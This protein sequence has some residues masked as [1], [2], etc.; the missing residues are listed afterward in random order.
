MTNGEKLRAMSDEELS[1]KIVS[2]KYVKYCTL[3]IFDKGA[4]CRHKECEKCIELW[5]KEESEIE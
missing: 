1:K 5:L 2:G 3:D 4:P